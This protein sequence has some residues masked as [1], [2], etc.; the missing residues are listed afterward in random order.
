MFIVEPVEDLFG[1]LYFRPDQIAD[2]VY[3]EMENNGQGKI[4]LTNDTKSGHLLW[5]NGSSFKL[6]FKI[7]FKS[8]LNSNNLILTL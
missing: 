7:K 1:N 6:N 4:E 3:Q 5:N 2:L 8:F